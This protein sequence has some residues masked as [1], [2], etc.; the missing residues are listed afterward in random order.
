MRKAGAT[1]KSMNGPKSDPTET[2]IVRRLR[3]NL[4]CLSNKTGLSETSLLIRTDSRHRQVHFFAVLFIA[5][6]SVSQSSMAR[7]ATI[8][9]EDV[10]TA[11]GFSERQKKAVFSGEV[12]T[13]DAKRIAPNEV[14][15][16]LAA[17]IPIPFAK[18]FESYSRGQDNEVSAR[19][20]AMGQV[21]PASPTAGWEKARFSASESGEVTDLLTATPG[22][23][24]N[25][26][27]KEFTELRDGMAKV[28]EAKRVE[29]FSELYRG[30]L[31]RRMRSY[32][33]KGL[34][35]VAPYA[36]EKGEQTSPAE[37]IERLWNADEFLLDLDQFSSFHKALETFP[38]DQPPEMRH[39]FFW[40]KQHFESK[41]SSRPA[42]ILEHAGWYLGED[43]ILISNR[44]FY[45]GHSYNANQGVTVILPHEEDVIVFYLMDVTSDLAARYVSWIA[46][47]IAQKIMSTELESYYRRL[48]EQAGQPE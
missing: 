18:V 14:V 32:L 3:M 29:R 15:A 39:R 17:R 44:Q 24:F 35:S 31:Q 13:V 46:L 30:F 37:E 43:V 8:T 36:R 7:A 28:D 16:L 4:A 41:W 25:L 5:L 34:D 26:S 27:A 19:H 38:E 48:R 1:A 22:L 12:V 11:A 6:L 23:D 47:P 9:A 42:F 40:L 20:L 21:D 2:G 45:V 33:E 10:M